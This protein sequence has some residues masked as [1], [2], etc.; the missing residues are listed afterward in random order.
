MISQAARVAGFQRLVDTTDLLPDEESEQGILG[1]FALVACCFLIGIEREAYEALK[2][3]STGEG[4]DMFRTTEI[5]PVSAELRETR[6]KTVAAILDCAMSFNTDEMAGILNLLAGLAVDDST[7]EMFQIILP[8]VLKAARQP[9]LWSILE[10]EYPTICPLIEKE[11]SA[12][13]SA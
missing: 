11:W 4:P 13:L 9:S 7:D 1:V 6:I 5:I 12:A 10:R 2:A 8:L 3:I